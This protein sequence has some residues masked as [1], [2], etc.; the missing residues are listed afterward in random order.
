MGNR[1]SG[2]GSGSGSDA[3]INPAGQ[4]FYE[5]ITE[6]PAAFDISLID[7]EEFSNTINTIDI[8]WNFDQLIP[9]DVDNQHLNITGD[10]NQRVLP[11]ITDIYFEISSNE[12]GHESTTIATESISV[13][14]GHNYNSDSKTEQNITISKNSTT[15]VGTLTYKT[16]NLFIAEQDT[17][18]YTVSVYGKN[19]SNGT[20]V[21]KL[22]Y[23]GLIFKSTGIP[24]IPTITSIGDSINSNN[25]I[26]FTINATTTDMDKD[27]DPTVLSSALYISQLDLSHTLIDSVRSFVTYGLPTHTASD[28]AT[29]ITYAN[30]ISGGTDSAGNESISI[31]PTY[32][33]ANGNF[34]FGSKYTM[35]QN[36]WHIKL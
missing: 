25:V 14:S 24:E 18:S 29:S 31:S 17:F 35:Q 5:I 8:A 10:L 4:A 1:Q 7:G 21:N 32:S 22:T 36:I 15:M 33:S 3:A 2:S 19:N 27:T 34:Y 20:D 23:T 12:A 26:T 30:N 9:T 13:D 28:D 6:Q 16:L 11:C